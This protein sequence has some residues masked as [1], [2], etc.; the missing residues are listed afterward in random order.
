MKARGPGPAQ[1]MTFALAAAF[2][3]GVA[4]LSA[5]PSHGNVL[6]VTALSAVS[7]VIIA[8]WPRGDTPL[9]AFALVVLAWAVYVPRPTWWVIL[10]AVALVIAHTC[11]AVADSTR[12]HDALPGPALARLARRCAVVLVIACAAGLA[13]VLRYS[14][15]D[16]T[17]TAAGVVG[18]L[19]LAMWMSLP[20]DRHREETSTRYLPPE[21]MSRSTR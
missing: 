12:G 18:C 1:R 14:S 17:H 16:A 8:L 9:L 7:V 5:I 13:T 6:P 2:A 19:L 15:H 3:T 11:L 4:G 20:R 21:R 10:G